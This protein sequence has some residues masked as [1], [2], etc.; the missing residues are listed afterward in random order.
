MECPFVCECGL[1]MFHRG[2]WCCWYGWGELKASNGCI[3]LDMIDD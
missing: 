2:G 3:V 1:C